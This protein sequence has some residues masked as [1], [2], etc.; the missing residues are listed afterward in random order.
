MGLL[1]T[2]NI[3]LTVVDASLFQQ[4]AVNFDHVGSSFDPK[5]YA[6]TF[7][8][9]LNLDPANVT[10]LPWG[11][12]SESGKLLLKVVD[13]MTQQDGAT[14]RRRFSFDPSTWTSTL[15]RACKEVRRSDADTFR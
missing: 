5:L 7:V 1:A 11:W 2:S 9:V 10:D 12:D 4:T 14:S 13:H 15:R 3:R 6:E 8:D